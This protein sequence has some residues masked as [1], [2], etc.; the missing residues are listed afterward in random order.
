MNITLLKAL[1]FLQIYSFLFQDHTTILSWR[2]YLESPWVNTH[3]NTR[4]RWGGSYGMWITACMWS[5]YQR[6]SDC[7]EL[8]TIL[9]EWCHRHVIVHTCISAQLCITWLFSFLLLDILVPAT[10]LLTDISRWTLHHPPHSSLI[11]MKGY[12]EFSFILCLLSL[13]FPTLGQPCITVTA[14]PAFLT[15]EQRAMYNLLIH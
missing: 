11:L 15:L 8:Q 14:Q 5:I 10:L 2:L 13:T 1:I 7:N 12:G 6:H 4:W 3:L 9:W